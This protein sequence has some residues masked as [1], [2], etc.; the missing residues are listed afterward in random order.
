MRIIN[1]PALLL[2]VL[3]QITRICLA[4][5]Q[6][7]AKEETKVDNPEQILFQGKVNADNINIR[8]D[9][10]ISSEAICKLNKNEHVDVLAKLYD[11]YK[12]KL[13]PDAPSF[14]NKKFVNLTEDKTAE[15]SD[16]N[17]NI[18]LRPDTSA[19]ILGRV[20]KNEAVDILEDKGD[21]YRIKPIPKSSGWIHK[22]FVDKIEKKKIKLAKKPETVDNNITVA[23]TLKQKTFTRVA[24]HKLITEDGK[25]YLLRGNKENL[26]SFNQRRVK[27]SG[28]IADPAQKAHLIIEVEKIEA[29]D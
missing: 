27:I 25:V 28:K 3:L 8:A 15:V 6:G 13:P 5:E 26:A 24:T 4:E 1:K 11:W 9:S 20:N 16:D 21:W 22:S 19:P 12:I 14:I 29:L 18:R 17:V 10:T 7:Q 23:G 2:F